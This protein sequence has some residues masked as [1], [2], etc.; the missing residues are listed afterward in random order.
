MRQKQVE[1][2]VDAVNDISDVLPPLICFA[3]KSLPN[4]LI[5]GSK[6]GISNT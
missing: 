4:N 5:A 3:S 1:G 2:A 6:I